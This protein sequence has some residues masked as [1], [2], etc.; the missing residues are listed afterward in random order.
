M[1]TGPGLNSVVFLS[2]KVK[3]RRKVPIVERQKGYH[4]TVYEFNTETLGSD[5]GRDESVGRSVRNKS[6]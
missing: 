2:Y 4:L 5:H 1:T 3:S 6:S